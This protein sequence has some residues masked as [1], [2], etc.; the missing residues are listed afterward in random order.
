[1]TNS[2]SLKL[3][4]CIINVPALERMK[5]FRFSIILLLVSVFQALEEPMVEKHFQEVVLAVEKSLK[6]GAEGR[7]NYLNKL[8][9]IY[10]DILS[11]SKEG[12]WSAL[13]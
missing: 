5:D 9:H 12:V 6:Q 13:L 10:R 7:A 8:Q 11:A 3:G 4:L 2:I 1:M